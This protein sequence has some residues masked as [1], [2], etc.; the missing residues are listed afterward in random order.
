MKENLKVNL[1]ED[2]TGKGIQHRAAQQRK[3]IDIILEYNFP[4]TREMQSKWVRSILKAGSIP[5]MPIQ[6][7]QKACDK[8]E[9]MGRKE[10]VQKDTRPNWITKKFI[11]FFFS[12]PPADEKRKSTFS[13]RRIGQTKTSIVKP[14][15]KGKWIKPKKRKKKHSSGESIYMLK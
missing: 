4:S 14:F 1:K 13:L 6:R 3:K 11:W 10:K 7:V 5:S 12:S 8:Q 9:A 15:W 2:L